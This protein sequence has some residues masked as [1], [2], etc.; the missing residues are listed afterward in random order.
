[1]S[2]AWK[3]DGLCSRTGMPD[4]WF[5]NEGRGGGTGRAAR[6]REQETAL[7]CKG[8]P[9]VDKCLEVAIHNGEQY[10]IW[11]GTTPEQ[12]RRLLPPKQRRLKPISHGTESGYKT[13]LRRDEDP[14]AECQRENSRAVRERKRRS[15]EQTHN[16]KDAA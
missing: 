9:V 14:C 5:P 6:K 10:G 3:L 2:D 4:D 8:C 13:H 1:M 15:R 7:I 11:G 16:E 12:R